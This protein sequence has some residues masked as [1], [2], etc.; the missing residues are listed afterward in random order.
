MTSAAGTTRSSA[1]GPQKSHTGQW[2]IDCWL[3]YKQRSAATCN[4]DETPYCDT[5]ALASGYS[6]EDIA[7]GKLTAARGGGTEAKQP[8]QGAEVAQPRTAGPAATIS[9]AP[10]AASQPAEPIARPGRGKR[11]LVPGYECGRDG[12]SKPLT[13]S[14]K[15]GYCQAHFS[16]SKLKK[17]RVAANPAPGPKAPKVGAL[18]EATPR[19]APENER[20]CIMCGKTLQA[21]NKSGLCPTHEKKEAWAARPDWTVAAQIPLA[22]I[23]TWWERLDPEVKANIFLAE[24]LVGAGL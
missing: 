8:E 12:C 1:A 21:G 20:C 3:K 9:A 10:I 13:A 19:L 5:H 6:Q 17:T 24:L 23:N 18:Q 15:S 2:C 22:L 11:Q 4:L 16:D 14:N 7:A